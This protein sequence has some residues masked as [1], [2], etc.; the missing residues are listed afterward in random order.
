LQDLAAIGVRT[1]DRDRL[2]DR[3]AETPAS[4]SVCAEMV[5]FARQLHQCWAARRLAARN[6]WEL[7]LFSPVPELA[8]HLRV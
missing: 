7:A 6:A 1:G 2:L 4:A 3:K 5:R 8:C